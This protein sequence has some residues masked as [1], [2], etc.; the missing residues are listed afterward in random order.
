MLKDVSNPLG[1]PLICFLAPYCF[2]ILGV[3]EDNAAGMLQN[4][5]N[6]NPVLSSGLHAHIFAVV[7]CQPSRAPAQISGKGGKPLALVGCH[8][9]VIGRSNTG[10]DKGLV[11]IHPT[12]DRVDN[13]EHNTSP[14]NSI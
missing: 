7:F 8:S 9:V 1:V 5:V 11:D 6:G 3:S 10:N 2:H 4:V 13:F 14:Q 12:A